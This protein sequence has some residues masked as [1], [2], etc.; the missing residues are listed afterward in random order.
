MLL[1][2]LFIEFF[3]IGLFSIGGGLATVPF[4]NSLSERRGWFTIQDIGTMLA[5]SESTPGAIGVNMATFTGFRCAGITGAVIATIG[6]IVPSIIIIS[7]IA[8]ILESFKENTAVK[9][10]FSGLRPAATGLI[11]AA[12]ITVARFALIRE[13]DTVEILI[14]QSILF[15]S[16]CI[17]FQLFK[18]VHPIVFIMIAAAFGITFKW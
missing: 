7:I 15:I 12:G 6:L 10:V 9:A 11:A 4:L 1:F 5:V 17:S 3:N 16:F 13:T 14:P 8:R 18:R 2:L